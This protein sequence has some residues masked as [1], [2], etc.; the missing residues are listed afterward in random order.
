MGRAVG[1]KALAG[2]ILGLACLLAWPAH[3]Q[4]TQSRALGAT[5]CG[6]S[7]CHSAAAPWPNSAVRQIEYD[8]WKAEDPH[9]RSYTALS[10]ARAIS[11]ARTLGLGDPQSETTCL[12]CHAYVVPEAAREAT[13]D[14]TEGVT[15][16][17]CHGAASKWV[18]VHA[19]GLYFTNANVEAGMYPTSNPQARADLCMSCHI[20]REDKV[21]THAMLAA[22]HPRLSF[23]VNFYTWFASHEMTGRQSYAHF[24]VDDDYLQRKALP[25]GIK[26]W[27]VGQAKQADHVLDLVLSPKLNSG[28]FPELSLFRCEGCH[29]RI[30]TGSQGRGPGHPRL[31]DSNLFFVEG[32]AA[33]IAP[34]LAPTLRTQIA[35]LERSPGT[36]WDQVRTDAE[37]L[38]STLERLVTRVTVHDFSTDDTRAMIQ[39]IT[40]NRQGG[41]TN[42]FQTSEQAVLTVASLVDELWREDELSDARYAKAR[43]VLNDVLRHLESGGHSPQRVRAGFAE[44]N[45]T[46]FG[47]GN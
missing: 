3:A 44:V 1:R 33:N 36:S 5:T 20:G 34:D 41:A 30:E 11:I 42:D 27:A 2:F 22:G 47:Q 9:A 43:T 13:Y 21:V 17:A 15:C 10:S 25:Y 18:G 12:S 32:I 46:V 6:N 31:S 14:I 19:A 39:Y 29:Q 23:E 45:A 4:P 38:K 37:A 7:T 8:V 40:A 16:E 24:W 26:V 35:R 28:L